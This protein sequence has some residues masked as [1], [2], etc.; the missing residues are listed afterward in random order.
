MENNSNSSQSEDYNDFSI[1]SKEIE[2]KV[3]SL[4]DFVYFFLSIKKRIIFSV[5]SITAIGAIGLLLYPNHYI[6]T[7]SFIPPPAEMV[8][9]YNDSVS[10]LSLSSNPL[11]LMPKF[12]GFFGKDPNSLFVDVLKSRKI[13]EPIIYKFELMDEF[14]ADSIEKALIILDKKVEIESLNALVIIDVETKD[15][16][17]S[18]NLAKEYLIQL[19]DLFGKLS[20]DET[21]RGMKFLEE[22]LTQVHRNLILASK[23]L[24]DFQIKNK[25]VDVE[26]QGMALIDSIAQL[27]TEIIIAESELKSLKTTF[28]DE[29]PKV[30]GLKARISILQKELNNIK[31]K[32]DSKHFNNKDV[33]STDLN[34]LDIPS[35]GIGYVELLRD[36][37]IMEEVFILL[38]KE[39]ELTRIKD[40]KGELKFKI[41]EDAPIPTKKSKPKRA[42]TL[43]VIFILSLILNFFLGL[44]SYAFF[45]LKTF[46]P[47]TYD[48]LTKLKRNFFR[49]IFFLKKIP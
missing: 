41:I 45:K 19:S 11:G 28:T 9:G 42:M 21:S 10:L 43:I 12:G 33:F 40:A 35:F 36:V 4:A 46:S 7:A 2:E 47:S 5:F 3:N 23:K 38:N 16:E 20:K 27:Q 8:S 30:M 31:G 37:K 39:Y 32:N 1:S 26:K 44:F 29:S 18:S 48:I 6:A 34:L 22:R 14:K 13:Q 24:S 25:M 17:L 49:E 15:P